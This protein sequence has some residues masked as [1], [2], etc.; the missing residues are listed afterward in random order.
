[1]NGGLTVA[2]TELVLSE[3]VKAMIQLKSND[4]RLLVD[5]RKWF[6]FERNLDYFPTRKGIT[7]DVDQWKKIIP[8]IQNLIDGKT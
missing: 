2:T 8:M 7:L 4:N 6:K 1:M 5:V 3:T